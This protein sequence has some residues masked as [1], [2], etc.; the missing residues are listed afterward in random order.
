MHVLPLS[1]TEHISSLTNYIAVF[2][3]LF[4]ITEMNSMWECYQS[5]MRGIL[6]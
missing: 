3:V 1:I 5:F 4:L 2:L 6:P